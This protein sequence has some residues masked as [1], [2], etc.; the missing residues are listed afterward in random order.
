MS[1]VLAGIPEGIISN[2]IICIV[3]ILCVRIKIGIVIITYELFKT[4][5][6]VILEKVVGEA[7]CCWVYIDPRWIAPCIV[8]KIKGMNSGRIC[9]VELIVIFS[10]N[11]LAGYFEF[12]SFLTGYCRKQQTYRC[13]ADEVW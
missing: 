1:G 8:F 12:G 11:E 13:K 5:K 9:R 10:I 7:G 3:I 2:D 6:L 4:M